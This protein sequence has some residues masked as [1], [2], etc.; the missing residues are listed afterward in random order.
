MAGTAE[1]KDRKPRVKELIEMQ[2]DAFARYGD[3]AMAELRQAV[4]E[5]EEAMSE[6][7]GNPFAR[8][9]VCMLS[10]YGGMGTGDNGCG[11]YRCIICVGTV[12]HTR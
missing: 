8:W 11:C 3:K 2:H 4:K 5:A 7:E 9:Q 6:R 10:L 1:E 12:I